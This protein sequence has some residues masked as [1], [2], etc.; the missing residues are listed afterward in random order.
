LTFGSQAR[1]VKALIVMPHHSIMYHTSTTTLADRTRIGHPV[2]KGL[3]VGPQHIGFWNIRSRRC[4]LVVAGEPPGALRHG[5][6]HGSAIF[7]GDIRNLAYL[8]RLDAGSVHHA[9]K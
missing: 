5:S 2:F 8:L 3:N 4:G 7:I 6:L 1:E 9:A